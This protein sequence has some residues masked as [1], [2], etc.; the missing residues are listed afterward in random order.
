MSEEMFFCARALRNRCVGPLDFDISENSIIGL[1]GPSGCGKT[2]LLRNLSDIEPFEG[3]LYMDS[4]SWLDYRPEQWRR[5]VQL[6]PANALWWHE[7]VGEHFSEK[8]EQWSAMLGFDADIWNWG[9]ERLSSGERQRLALIRS[10]CRQPRLLLLD[11][12]TSNLD[13][14]NT[15]RLEE[16]VRLY[17][18][19]HQASVV[20]VSHN[21]EQLARLAHEQWHI[22]DRHIEMSKSP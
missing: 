11:E 5:M 10:L 16:L 19:T 14:K 12:P 17:I 9:V 13:N 7:R 8:N 3:S 18:K 21:L 1:E 4:R 2:M 15:M 20:W 22:K 6:V